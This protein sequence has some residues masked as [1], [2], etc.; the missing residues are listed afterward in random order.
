MTDEELNKLRLRAYKLCR[1]FLVNLA[2][3]KVVWTH[4]TKQI[5]NSPSFFKAAVGN[6]FDIAVLEW[7][8]LFVDKKSFY[9][10]GK[11][12]DEKEN[13]DFLREVLRLVNK[14]NEEFELYKKI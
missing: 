11:L 3:Y 8:K 9:Y 14:T 1:L 10:W 13:N 6:F 12:V 7:C 4:D 5:L 2:C